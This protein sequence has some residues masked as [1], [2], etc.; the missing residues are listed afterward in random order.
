MRSSLR[1]SDVLGRFGG[2]EFVVVLPRTD[3][4]DALIAA[5]RLR[6]AVASHEFRNSWGEPIRAT[7][8]VGVST[9]PGDG[10]TADELFREADGAL[11]EAKQAGR[12][13]VSAAA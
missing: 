1:L 11:Y 8:S 4:R 7:V 10:R 9:Y 5:E 12:N 2:D 3:P 6:Y 13:R